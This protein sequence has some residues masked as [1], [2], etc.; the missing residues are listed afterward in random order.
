MDKTLG[1]QVETLEKAERVAQDRPICLQVL[2]MHRSG[3]SML[4]RILSLLGAQLPAS[5][6]GANASNEA[7]HWESDMLVVC[8]DRFLASVQSSWNDWRAIPAS[9][10]TAKMRSQ[11]VADISAVLADE[12]PA[13]GL[14]VAKDPRVCR[15][16]DI[17]AEAVAEQRAEMKTII[18]LRNPLEVCESLERRDGMA[19][20][21]AGLLWLR[22]VLEAELATR[23]TRRSIIVHQDL[24]GD[25]RAVVGGIANSLDITWPHDVENIASDVDAF[26]QPGLHHHRRSNE[27]VLLDPTLRGWVS[28]AWEA[29][30]R[31]ARG[32][33][34]ERA[35]AELGRIKVEF[36]I[37]APTIYEL[38]QQIASQYM[39]VVAERDA[40][41]AAATA[42]TE[43]AQAARA[44]A[45][46][47]AHDLEAALQA[48][49]L[50]AEAR[51]KD[52]LDLRAELAARDTRLVETRSEISSIQVERDSAAE[53]LA[54]SNGE[55]TAL[56]AAEQELQAELVA[57]R[58]KLER[59]SLSRAKAETAMS[60]IA[61]DLKAVEDMC[62]G[63]FA[64]VTLPLPQIRARLKELSSFIAST[65]AALSAG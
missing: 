55:A 6:M 38:R 62:S 30:L 45:E 52:E 65:E 25:W 23:G 26:I 17:Y 13:P 35:Y 3:T 2:G 63:N 31:L 57:L 5:L 24:M 27:D 42:E 53:M 20:G 40:Q 28:D 7:G 39:H 34:I 11:A 51:D 19:R 58:A 9:K 1:D 61:R 44:E 18:P 49:Q 46:V 36:E 56:R 64:R 43:Q 16:F 47:R 4:S 12:Y 15:F 10:I 59:L 33:E 54:R 32:Q 48:A 21:D 8:H 37:A 29:L 22:H 50:Q 41:L 60:V 14:F